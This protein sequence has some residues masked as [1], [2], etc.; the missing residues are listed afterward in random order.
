M[1]VLRPQA[2]SDYPLYHHVEEELQAES[3]RDAAMR[4]VLLGNMLRQKRRE[5][6]ATSSAKKTVFNERAKPRAAKAKQ[7]GNQTASGTTND[8][9]ERYRKKQLETNKGLVSVV[10]GWIEKYDPQTYNRFKHEDMERWVWQLLNTIFQLMAWRRQE[11]VSSSDVEGMIKAEQ[12]YYELLV[13]TV[14]YADR[15]V[16][17][18]GLEGIKLFHLLGVSA[19]CTIKY[20]EERNDMSN[21]TCAEAIGVSLQEV[22]AM[23]RSFIQG[24]GYSFTLTSQ[25]VANFLF[26][27]M[28]YG[29]YRKGRS[30]L[31][32]AKGNLT[33]NQQY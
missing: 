24:L 31:S 26:Y 28:R 29:A 19:L 18:R 20:W 22:N 25:D 9:W 23:E 1:E 2:L 7:A 11:V 15:Y 33:T 5:H 8:T 17:A 3:R 21:K 30:S 12:G 32:G 4:V 14:I 6:R 10:M 27:N 13:A 16:K